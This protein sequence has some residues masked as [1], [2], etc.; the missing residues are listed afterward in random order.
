MLLP[1]EQ[2]FRFKDHLQFCRFSAKGQPLLKYS[3]DHVGAQHHFRERWAR[4]LWIYES[5][6]QDSCF[7]VDCYC[8]RQTMPFWGLFP[9]AFYSPG[10]RK[11]NFSARWIQ[12]SI[13]SASTISV[14]LHWTW[15]K[16][17]TARSSASSHGLRKDFSH[18]IQCALGCVRN[19]TRYVY[20]QL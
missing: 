12:N 18:G 1:N 8:R 7:L 9:C 11:R 5:Q 2:R 13:F 19:S 4:V 10:W 6:T 20:K 16:K 17:D 3:V 14:L 15:T